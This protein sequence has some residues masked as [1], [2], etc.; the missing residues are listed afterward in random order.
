GAGHP[1]LHELN[2]NTPAY[3]VGRAHH[4][5]K[6]FRDGSFDNKFGLGLKASDIGPTAVDALQVM[7]GRPVKVFGLTHFPKGLTELPP[8]R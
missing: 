8:K 3:R 6:R 7:T 2:E 4:A 1:P 5:L